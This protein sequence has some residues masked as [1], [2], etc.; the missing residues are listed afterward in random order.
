M[1]TQITITGTILKET[2]KAMQVEI[3]WQHIETPGKMHN[4]TTWVPKSQSEKLSN[5]NISV[6]KWLGDK[7]GDEIREKFGMAK[8]LGGSGIVYN[9]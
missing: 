6:P 3:V 5:N 2:E 4:Y 7:I 8:H 9:F 1:K